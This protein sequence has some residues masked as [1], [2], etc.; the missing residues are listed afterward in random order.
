MASPLRFVMHVFS[1]LSGWKKLLVRLSVV[2]VVAGGGWQVYQLFQGEGTAA[3]QSQVGTGTSSSTD[4]GGGGF[5]KAGVGYLGGFLL[6]ALFRMFLKVSLLAT[7]VIAGGLFGLTYLGVDLPW[8]SFGETHASLSD[9]VAS[10]F[11]SVKTLLEGYLPASA[12]SGLG[13]FSG[14]TTKPEA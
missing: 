1:G 8:S 7:G 4:S 6:G 9:W 10:Q 11:A 3:A 5:W 13:V 2:L 12:M 14:A